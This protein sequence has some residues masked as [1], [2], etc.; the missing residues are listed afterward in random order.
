MKWDWKDDGKRLFFVTIAAIIYGCNM[1]SFIQAGSL[2][3]GGIAGITVLIQRICQTYFSLEVPF[4]FI[5]LTLNAIPILIGFRFIGKKFTIYSCVMIVLSSILTDIIPLPHLT[6]DLLLICVFGGLIN[7]FVVGL[8]LM[9]RACSGGLDFVSIFISDQYHKDT[10]NYIFAVNVVILTIAGILFGWEKTLYSI[11]FQF[12]STQ[13]VHMMYQKYKQHTLLI[14]T[15]HPLEVY[16][17]ILKL[18]NHSGTLFQGKGLYAHENRSMVYSVVSSA[19][20]KHVVNEIHKTDPKAFINVIRT[21]QV[22]G[23]FHIEKNN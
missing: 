6:T 18:S 20:V 2:Y 19:E 10:W 11:I 16:D 12:T 8:C 5:N 21:D 9:G 4:A 22:D 7:G 23:R 13:V 15:N 1:K 3:P 17:I 14:I